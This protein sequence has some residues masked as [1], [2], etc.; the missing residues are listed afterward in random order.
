MGLTLSIPQLPMAAPIHVFVSIVPQQYFVEQISGGLVTTTVMV[1]PG[2]SP[3]TYEPR[4]NQMKA[5]A[6]TKLYF[7]MGVPFESAWLPK[8]ASANPDMKIVF[9][10]RGIK[11]I[12]MVHHDHE[13]E[14]DH[15]HDLADPH[16][17]LSP[18]LVKIQAGHMLESLVEVDPDHAAIYRAN[19]EVFLHKLDRLDADIRQI[20]AGYHGTRFMVFH[21]SWGYFASTYGLTQI[22]VE[23]EGKSPKLAQLQQ[24][25]T[26]A[27]RLEIKV[28]FAQPQFSRK[29]A[30]LIARAIGG[31]VVLADPL[32]AQWEKN[33]K[34]QATLFKAAL[35]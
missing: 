2:A 27:L 4:P 16:I 26:K 15:H 17:W 9:T 31:Q 19:Y 25:I 18:P 8:I 14:N 12:P 5:L 29:S 35:K 24:L 3:A 6:D 10:D 28:I 21:P 20:L 13:A 23:I 30:Q 32:A 33:L 7:A 11:K 1:P 34:D 22:P